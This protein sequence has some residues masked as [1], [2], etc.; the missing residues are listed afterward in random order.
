MEGWMEGWRPLQQRVDY[1]CQDDADDAK[2][3]EARNTR[4]AFLLLNFVYFRENNFD[5]VHGSLT[6]AA[7]AAV[8]WDAIGAHCGTRPHLQSGR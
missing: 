6:A 2:D 4:A 1:T 7:A 5:R 8:W 3:D